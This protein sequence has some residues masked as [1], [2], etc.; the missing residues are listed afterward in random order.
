[1]PAMRLL[2]R[3]T[4]AQRSRRL[5]HETAQHGRASLRARLERLRVGGRPILQTAIAASAAWALANA[6]L[7]SGQ[8]VF[9]PVAAVISLGVTVGQ[10]G[11][12]A[13]ELIGGV[14]VGITMADLLIAVIGTG[15]V[16]VGVV[17]ALAMAAATLLGAG[18]LLVGEAGVSA[19]LIAILEPPGGGIAGYRAL[20]ALIGGAVALGV[21]YLFF[22]MNP[23]L[24]VGRAAQRV[25]SALAKTL[26][27]TA[28]ALEGGDRERAERALEQ[29]R[30]IDEDLSAFGEALAT[31]Y[32][33]ARLAPPRRRALGH[34]EMYAQAAPQVDLVVRNTRVLARGAVRVVG[35]G[36]PAPPSLPEAV[37]DLGEAVWALAAQLDE[38][39]RDF[40]TRELALRAAGGATAL[41]EERTDLHV[42]VAVGAIRSAAVDLLCASGM[43]RAA[44][45]RAVEDAPRPAAEPADEPLR[46]ET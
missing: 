16:Q 41:L 15:P 37:R 10:R 18:A 35:D 5:S 38:P 24:V 3:R 46:A 20:E 17:V 34:L 42:S 6:I 21:N 23:E 31:G 14:V 2:D 11:R 29:A 33:T 1:M 28:G 19:T 8:P 27:E 13:V 45:M 25:L 44:A 4:L 12:R 22:P 9:A 36:Q 40:Q 39:E 43:D 26:G 30:A 7:S 32:E